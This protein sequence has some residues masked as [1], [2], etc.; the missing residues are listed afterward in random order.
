M[1]DILIVFV[2]HP[3][4]GRVKTRLAAEVGAQRAAEIYRG[5][6]EATLAAARAGW[7][8]TGIVIAYDPPEREAELAAWLGQDLRYV[9]QGEGDLGA[10]LA[11]MTGI[12]FDGGATNVTVIGSDCPLLSA[13][14]LHAARTAL[15]DGNVVIGPAQDGG[16]YLIGLPRAM[17]GLFAGIPWS[18][19]EV[20]AATRTRLEEGEAPF[21][22][23]PVLADVDTAADLPVWLDARGRNA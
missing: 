4:A 11:R 22:L 10:R 2:K 21:A 8:R 20:F 15:E 18:T 3:E 16:Y 1:A 23:L 19:G 7:E 17:P 12:A 14:H 9:A 13:R 6:A 5:L